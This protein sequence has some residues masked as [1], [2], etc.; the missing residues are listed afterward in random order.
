MEWT[1][2]IKIRYVER[3][4]NIKNKSQK[5]SYD[6]DQEIEL[7]LC[8]MFLNSTKIITGFKSNKTTNQS[9]FYLYDKYLLIMSADSSK[10]LTLYKVKSSEK[11]Y[12]LIF[13]KKSI[14]GFGLRVK[15]LKNKERKQ[16]LKTNISH[17]QY[18]MAIDILPKESPILKRAMEDYAYNIN[19]MI[20]I[21]REKKNNNDE[22]R[23]ITLRLIS[24][25]DY[26]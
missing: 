14:D 7:N 22:L 24:M 20:N 12:T 1:R 2:H 17:G 4:L 25:F 3:V 5:Y 13:L 18:T 16:S 26:N 8:K 23:S 21:H 9:N 15:Q 6:H 19:E 11:K 10:G